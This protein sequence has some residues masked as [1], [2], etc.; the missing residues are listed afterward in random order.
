[1]LT[2]PSSSS[3]PKSDITE[4]Q[5]MQQEYKTQMDASKVSH[6]QKTAKQQKAIA[7]II[8]EKRHNSK[9]QET[10]PWDTMR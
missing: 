10:L 6:H 7:A 5:I 3:I 1:M 4:Y 2:T 8:A 9:Q